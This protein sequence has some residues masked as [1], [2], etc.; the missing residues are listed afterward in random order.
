MAKPVSLHVNGQSVTVNDDDVARRSTR[1][2]RL[3]YAYPVNAQSY[4]K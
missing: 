4:K 3:K 2:I 1:Q